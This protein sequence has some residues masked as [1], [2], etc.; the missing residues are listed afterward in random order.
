MYTA[1]DV[2][3]AIEGLKLFFEELQCNRYTQLKHIIHA[4]D[5]K[6]LFLRPGYDC[7]LHSMSD[8]ARNLNSDVRPDL[9]GLFDTWN[10]QDVELSKEV[11]LAA[12]RFLESQLLAI[13]AE[14]RELAVPSRVRDFLFLDSDVSQDVLVH[15]GGIS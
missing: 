6:F 15:Q 9:K 11:C 12:V 13:Q 3:G 5:E 4:L 14:E 2:S 10:K 1:T 8:A 7:A